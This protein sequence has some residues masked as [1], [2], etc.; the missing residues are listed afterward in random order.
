[1]NNFAESQIKRGPARARPTPRRFEIT[2]SIAAHESS[3]YR[4]D[5]RGP[6]RP[7]TELPLVA[8]TGLRARNAK[9]ARLLA[10]PQWPPNQIELAQPLKSG[11]QARS[12]PRQIKRLPLLLSD[13]RNP[14]AQPGMWYHIQ[15]KIATCGHE[16]IGG[17][18]DLPVAP[19]VIW[20]RVRRPTY[21][22]DGGLTLHLQH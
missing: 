6:P 20:Q 18:T 19:P 8:S 7:H 16:N 1:M 11:P 3:R 21:A 5:L 13:S 12:K 15:V 2:S 14:L 17:K 4:L 22:E 9:E 10:T